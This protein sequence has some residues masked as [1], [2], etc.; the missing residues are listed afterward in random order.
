[1]EINYLDDESLIDL[2]QKHKDNDAIGILYKRY[3][4]LVFGLAFKYFKQEDAAKDMV[5]EI[6]M[7]VMDKLAQA[8]TQKPE[9]FA[10]WLYIVSRNEIISVLRKRKIQVDTVDEIN[11]EKFM[12]SEEE[13]RPIIKDIDE[14]QLDAAMSNLNEEQNKCI[15]LFYLQEKSYQE[16]A[17]LTGYDIKKVKSYIQNGKRNLKMFLTKKM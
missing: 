8:K 14:K 6:F 16:V 5:T 7:K 4:M 9:S 11:S 2:Y 3:S 15:H 13:I 17:S 12:E 1:M 10:K